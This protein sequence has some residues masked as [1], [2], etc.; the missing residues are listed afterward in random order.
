VKQIT[1]LIK[2]DK[3]YQPIYLPALSRWT[4]A[5]T[6]LEGNVVGTT[7]SGEFNYREQ[8]ITKLNE[9]H[10]KGELK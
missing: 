2:G 10:M 4:V 8:A 6:D 1:H 7:G 3:I 9:M 5:V